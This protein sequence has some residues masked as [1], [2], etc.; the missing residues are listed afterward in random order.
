M[1]KLE[2]FIENSKS[3]KEISSAAEFFNL[4]LSLG[5]EEIYLSIFI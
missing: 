2:M 4:G 3:I 5:L 1:I